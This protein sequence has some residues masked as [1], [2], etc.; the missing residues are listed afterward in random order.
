MLVSLTFA[1]PEVTFVLLNQ[2]STQKSDFSFSE[3]QEKPSL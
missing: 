3:N 1:N 2:M